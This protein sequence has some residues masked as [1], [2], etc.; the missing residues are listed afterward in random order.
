MAR[1]YNIVNANQ[2]DGEQELPIQD[3]VALCSNGVAGPAGPTGPTGPTG[4]QGIQGTQG[5]QGPQGPKGD[6]GDQGEVG[7]IGPSGWDVPIG[8]LEGQVLKKLSDDDYDADWEDQADGIISLTKA[9]HDALTP[10]EAAGNKYITTDENEGDI[11]SLIYPVGSIYMSVLSSNPTLL[12]GGTWVAWGEGQVPVG[13][14]ATDSDF[15]TVEKTGGSKIS[16]QEHS[17]STPNH[18]HVTGNHSADHSH[19]LSVSGT[20]SSDG[21]HDHDIYYRSFS[22][23]GGANTLNVL[24]TAYGTYSDYCTTNGA[25]THTVTST[26]TSGG[27]SAG[28]THSIASSGGGTSGNAGQTGSTNLQPYI[29][30]YMWKRTA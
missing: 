29:T 18:T 26:G 5:A 13:V 14:K 22:L 23:E 24:S 16:F 11:F 4:P 27:A 28:H 8:G 17:H 30:C 2:P 3:L 12:F 25:H 7:P 6:Q 19:S 15:D 21:S 9:E 20:T 10:E 1:R